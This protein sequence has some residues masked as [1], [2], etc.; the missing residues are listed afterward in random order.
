MAGTRTIRCPPAR[1]ASRSLN[2]QQLVFNLSYVVDI[3]GGSKL[4]RVPWTK[5]VLDN[6]QFS[7]ITTFANGGLSN[8]GSSA[9]T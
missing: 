4:T 3:P 5:W 7:G 2:V 1:P 8:I 9:A 6:W